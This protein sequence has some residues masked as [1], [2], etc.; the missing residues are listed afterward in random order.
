MIAR[1]L[2]PFFDSQ[3]RLKRGAIR[4]HVNDTRNERVM[5]VASMN[6]KTEDVARHQLRTEVGVYDKA[7]MQRNMVDLL[8]R[9]RG[10]AR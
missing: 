2:L 8:G 4:R 9:V 6:E 3:G 7:A 1:A 10:R 5:V